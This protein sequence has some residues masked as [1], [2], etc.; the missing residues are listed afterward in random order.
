MKII[1][2]IIQAKIYLQ[3]AVFLAVVLLGLSTIGQAQS[4]D[5]IDRYNVVWNSPSQSSDG[6]MPIGNGAIGLNVWVEVAK[7]GNCDICRTFTRFR[8][9]A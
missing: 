4:S 9:M 8:G 2:A 5:Q 3:S 7:W 1:I 6:S